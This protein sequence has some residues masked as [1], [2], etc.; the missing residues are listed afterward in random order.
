MAII[1]DYLNAIGRELQTGK[2]AEHSYRP[3]LRQFLV[4][5]GQNFSP[6]TDYNV[7][8]EP[9]RIAGNAPDFL[10]QRGG[11]SLGWIET[12]LPG[13]DLDTEEGVEQLQ[14]YRQAFPNLILTDYL[15][16]RLYSA[17]EKC[18]SVCIADIDDTTQ[19]LIHRNTDNNEVSV[20]LAEFFS[21]EPLRISK[22]SDLARNAQRQGATAQGL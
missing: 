1:N 5:W 6:T 11:A 9:K 21:A 2:A 22:A 14:R 12:K 8:N 19:R 13:T 15:E 3:M 4:D 18:L 20:F 16:F 10:I 17:G 7:T